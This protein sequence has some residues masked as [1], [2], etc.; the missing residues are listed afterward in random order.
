MFSLCTGCGFV[1]Q[2]ALCGTIGSLA[3]LSVW[4]PC[5][6]KAWSFLSRGLVMSALLEA[7]KRLKVAGRLA[8]EQLE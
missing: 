4:D 8:P 2:G 7:G 5:F 1:L 3:E 6:G